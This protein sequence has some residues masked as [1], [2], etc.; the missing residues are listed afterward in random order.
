[1]QPAPG[2]QKYYSVILNLPIGSIGINKK[3]GWSTMLNDKAVDLRSAASIQ[4]FTL[5]T[6]N[7]SS[8]FSLF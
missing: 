7:E 8:N 6:H 2:F 1:M 5:Q 3:I 4:E